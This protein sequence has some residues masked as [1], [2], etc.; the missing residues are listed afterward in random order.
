M[1]VGNLVGPSASGPPLRHARICGKLV[2][3]PRRGMEEHQHETNHK[4]DSAGGGHRRKRNLAASGGHDALGRRELRRPDRHGGYRPRPAGQVEPEPIRPQRLTP[5]PHHG[6]GHRERRCLRSPRRVDGYRRAAHP[7]GASG[8]D[9]E[10]RSLAH[11][12][13]GRVR[14]RSRVL[15]RGRGG[16]SHGRRQAG[17]VDHFRRLREHL[18][19]RPSHLGHRRELRVLQPN[20]DFRHLR[21]RDGV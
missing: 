2:P 13:H 15:V 14:R 16:Q 8:N 9:S 20:P 6:A 10:R 4:P 5:E 17:P 12:Q 11:E 19:R 21:F 18:R 1:Q 3:L 7:A